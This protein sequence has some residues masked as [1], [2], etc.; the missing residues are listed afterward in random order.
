LI[1]QQH[2]PDLPLSQMAD[3]AE[4]QRQRRERLAAKLASASNNQKRGFPLLTL[5][6]VF[7]FLV[8]LI[9]FFDWLLLRL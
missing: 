3:A 9:V 7:V 1:N 8:A 2:Q 5:T 4:Q 6:V